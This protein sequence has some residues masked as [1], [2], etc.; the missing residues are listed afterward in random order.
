MIW[1]TT[2]SE[3]APGWLAVTRLGQAELVLPAALMAISVL[4]VQSETRE[5]DLRWLV[6]LALAIALTLVTKVAFI[7]WGIGWAELDFTGISGHAMCAAATYPILFL[8]LASGRSLRW[9]VALQI[10]GWGLAL[11]VA[12]SRIK[13]GAHSPSEVVAGFLLGAAVSAVALALAKADKLVFAMRPVAV[14]VL[15]AWFFSGGSAMPSSQTH[16]RITRLALA[17]SGH[18]TPYMRTPAA[19]TRTGLRLLPNATESPN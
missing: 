19:Q 6:G 10:L 12:V 5:L 16:S 13:V 4:F 11:A 1:P 18:K 17:M 2:L 14:L 8:A 3:F 15:L 7:G 9:T